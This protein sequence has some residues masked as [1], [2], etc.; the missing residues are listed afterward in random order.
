MCLH[1]LHNSKVVNCCV[2][3]ELYIKSLERIIV[4]FGFECQL[5]FLSTGN[6]NRSR[7]QLSQLR[8]ISRRQFSKAID[9]MIYFTS[10][11]TRS[12]DLSKLF[13]RHKPFPVSN[14]RQE[15]TSPSLL[16]QR[17]DNR[18]YIYESTRVSCHNKLSE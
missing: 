15:D 3:L 16:L 4:K 7:F 1:E 10:T 13:F 8:S 9:H 18:T 2:Q 11:Y 6:V 14:R 5:L 12:N 17:T